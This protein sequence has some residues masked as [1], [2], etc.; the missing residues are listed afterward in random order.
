MRGRPCVPAVLVVGPTLGAHGKR[1]RAPLFCF[2][3]FF[4]I[5]TFFRLQFPVGVAVS[6]SKENSEA[7]KN[8][9]EDPT[10]Y[11]YDSF[12]DDIKEKRS[13]ITN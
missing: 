3:I 8:L 4:F 7:A 13:E 6:R 1:Q 10:I 5:F 9:M 11:D 2:Q 12:Y